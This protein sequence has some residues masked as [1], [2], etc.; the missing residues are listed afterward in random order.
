MK[1]TQKRFKCEYKSAKDCPFLDCIIHGI[2][3]ECD[4]Y[5][6]LAKTE[7]RTKE[8]YIEAYIHWRFHSLCYGCSHSK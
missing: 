7:P 8:E 4:N 3:V 2:L 1:K 6:C 5:E